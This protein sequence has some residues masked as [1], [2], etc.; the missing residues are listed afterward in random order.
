MNGWLIYNK[1]DAEHNKTYINWFLEEAH[2]QNISLRF[3]LREDLTIGVLDSNRIITLDG[4]TVTLPDFAVVR[5]I[6]PLFSRQ[7]ESFGVSVY[8]SAE[9]AAICNDKALT[10]FHLSKLS[11]P[12]ADTLFISGKTGLPELPPLTFPFVIKG[13]YGRGGS[14]IFLVRNTQE[15]R[16]L[17]EFEPRG[18]L[19]VQSATNVQPGKDV[20]VFV[21]GSEVIG[22]VLRENQ[23]DFRANYKLG[24]TASWYNLKP[25]EK[26]LV[27]QICE[28]FS[29][30]LVGIDFLLDYNG[31]F[32]FNEIEDVVGSRTLSAV[33]D[34]NILKKYVA[35]IK[36]GN[37]RQS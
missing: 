13:T 20:R 12:M 24:G 15:W 26:S 7:L 21:I 36:S 16:K 9:T 11:I 31:E 8:N 34:L 33:S 1:H 2:L 27:K 18:D 10:H 19:V 30:G 29:F 4:E 5:T 35:Y 28:C 37:S 32:V 22:A 3:V 14:E 17:K 23:H 25:H 6:E